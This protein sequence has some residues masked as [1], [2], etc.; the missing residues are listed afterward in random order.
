MKVTHFVAV[1]ISDADEAFRQTLHQALVAADDLHVVGL[2]DSVHETLELAQL[3]QPDTILLNAAL[4]KGDG[5]QAASAGLFSAG[6]VLLVSEAGAEAHT[7]ELLQL[8][9]RGCLVKGAG[10]L[11][12]LPDAIRAI[13]RGEA[14]LSPRLTGW[15]L[16][17]LRN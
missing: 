13:Y 12:K 4:L 3:L 6:K 1:L 10:L 2:A 17:T 11:D 16:D 8:G 7:L 14:V 9:A 15:M 5:A